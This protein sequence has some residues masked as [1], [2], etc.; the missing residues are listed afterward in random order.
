MS[1]HRKQKTA[2]SGTLDTTDNRQEAMARTENVAEDVTEEETVEETTKNDVEYVNLCENVD[3]SFTSTARLRQYAQSVF[4][5]VPR[6]NKHTIFLVGDEG[7][8]K[9]TVV[10]YV[11]YQIAKGECPEFFR[12]HTSAVYMVDM[13]TIAMNFET[14]TNAFSDLIE[15]AIADG[16]QNLIVYVTR[17]ETGIDLFR[18][19]YDEFIEAIDFSGLMNFK[20]LATIDDGQ[21]MTEEEEQNMADF[22]TKY[23]VPIKIVA[24]ELPKRILRVLKIRIDEL[25]RD[26]NVK[27]PE[28]VREVLFMCYY[29][30][31]F[32]EGVNYTNILND[33]DAFLSLVEASS[34][35]IAD[36]N[37][38]KKYYRASFEIMKKLSDD[39]NYITAIHES[40]HVLVALAIPKLYKLYGASIL[41][42][43]QTGIEGI[44]LTKSSL[45][46]AYNEQDIIDYAAMLLAGR[47]AEL[48][49]CVKKKKYGSILRR[50]Y[51]V[52]RGSSSD[53]QEATVA[54]R[55]WVAQNGAY[56][57]IGYHLSCGEW[58]SLT[59]IEK[60]K[61][62]VVVKRLLKQAYRKAE[63]CMKENKAF[64]MEMHKYLLDN[65]TA[66]IDDIKAIARKT[67]KNG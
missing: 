67:I 25:E 31:F 20:I 7:S 61:I 28:K 19:M 66:T 38:I 2:N 41:Y 65:M 35:S 43:A 9:S 15:T 57:F 37:D 4:N 23:S 63:L 56:R 26:H 45:Y 29:G 53:V 54:L 42:D 49:F 60:S 13:D 10:E 40:G 59:D 11:A 12:K 48:E 27:I 17:M 44:T 3:F 24:E 32:C 5:A 34:K 39:Y 1:K 50:R 36:C 46:R 58:D 30:K 8:G 18:G 64:I 55:E 21:Y 33:F 16:V 47:A 6:K 52:N 22:M 14:L 51:D 62:D